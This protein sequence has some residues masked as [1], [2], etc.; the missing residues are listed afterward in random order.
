MPQLADLAPHLEEL[1]KADGTATE[2]QLSAVASLGMGELP[3]LSRTQA[4]ALLSA[5]RYSEGVLHA[6]IGEM[7]GYRNER[8]IEAKAVEF[9]IR[10]AALRKRVIMWNNRSFARGGADVPRPKKDEHYA[11]VRQHLRELLQW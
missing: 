11:R 10:D 8:W 1:G 5:R 7:N 3:G 6:E 2:R 9:I 4:S